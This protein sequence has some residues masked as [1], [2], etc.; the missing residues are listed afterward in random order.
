MIVLIDCR[1]AMQKDRR[2]SCDRFTAATPERQFLPKPSILGQIEL[3][4]WTANSGNHGDKSDEEARQDVLAPTKYLT[5]S[6]LGIT[7]EEERALVAV[8]RQLESGKLAHTVTP[9]IR[10]GFNMRWAYVKEP[11]GTI[12]CIGGWMARLMKK[13]DPDVYVEYERSSALVPLFFPAHK[14]WEMIAAAQA[15]QAIDNFRKTGDGEEAWRQTACQS[16]ACGRLAMNGISNGYSKPV[17]ST[18]RRKSNCSGQASQ[19]IQLLACRS[20]LRS[21]TTR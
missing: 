3:F 20:Q 13:R 7:E 16:E 21:A 19:F 15:A 4:S 12:S 10:R 14:D 8:Q 1:C 18:D 11:C 9:T 6:E 17:A 2:Y 5:P